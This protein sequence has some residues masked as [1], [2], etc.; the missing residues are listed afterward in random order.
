MSA[1]GRRDSKKGEEFLRLKEQE[2]AKDA[3]DAKEGRAFFVISA[4]SLPPVQLRA[5]IFIEPHPEEVPA[6][7]SFLPSFHSSGKF[8]QA[9]APN[10][11][12][13]LRS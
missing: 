9:N 3:E 5:V 1:H 11:S 6:V 10:S 12:T 2:T 13:A 4:Q 7:V 8:S